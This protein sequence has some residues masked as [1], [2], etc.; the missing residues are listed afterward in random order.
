MPL[1]NKIKRLVYIKSSIGFNSN[2]D[3]FSKFEKYSVNKGKLSI[4]S[5]DFNSKVGYGLIPITDMTSAGNNMLL[6]ASSP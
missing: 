3:Y 2:V 1:K 6:L 5:K 4:E